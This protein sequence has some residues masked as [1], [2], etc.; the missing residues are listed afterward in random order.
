MAGGTDYGERETALY[1]AE[2]I[3]LQR[4]N[5]PIVYCGNIENRE[6]IKEIFEG[7]NFI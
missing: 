4:Y 6:E 7:K 3:S 5:K 1:N 2:F